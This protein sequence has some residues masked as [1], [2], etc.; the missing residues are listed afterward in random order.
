EPG[1]ARTPTA[2]PGDVPVAAGPHRPGR[3][4]GGIS[5][6]ALT[7]RGCGF[8]PGSPRAAA[9]RG[10]RPR[11]TTRAGQQNREEHP[12]EARETVHRAGLA[13][14]GRLALLESS[15]DVD[16]HRAGPGELAVVLDRPDVVPAQAGRP[17]FLIIG[18]LESDLLRLRLG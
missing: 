6:P 1:A 7:T 13:R 15:S 11:P 17:A 2:I 9:F 16:P 8:L 18:P 3:N 14:P 4:A 12:L 10:L 5:T